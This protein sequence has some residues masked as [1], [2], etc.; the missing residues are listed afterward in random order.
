M[1]DNPTQSK[2][3]HKTIHINPDLFKIPENN[4][5]RKKR[6]PTSSGED[7]IKFKQQTSPIQKNKS[8]KNKLLKYIREK[9]EE[10]YKKMFDE[11]C[12]K[13]ASS[14]PKIP[15]PRYPLGGEEEENEFQSSIHFFNQLEKE[16]PTPAPM[17]AVP[18]PVP[19]GSPSSPLR[20]S[21]IG[22][23]H[24]ATVKQRPSHGVYFQPL[25][26]HCTPPVGATA[27]AASAAAPCISREPPKYG[28]LKNGKLPTY[29][30]FMNRTLNNYGSL[31]SSAAPCQITNVSPHILVQ[32]PTASLPVPVPPSLESALSPSTP[33]KTAKESLLDAITE[34]RKTKEFLS[35]HKHPISPYPLAKHKRKFFKQKKTLRRTYHVG[36]SKYHP[37]V[38]VLVSNRTIRNHVSTKSQL[39]KQVS[40]DEVKLYL[41]KNGFIKVGSN[42]PEDVLRKMYESAVLIGGE[43]QNHNPENLLYNYLHHAN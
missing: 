39:L 28:C 42:A 29:R 10:N 11:T 3:E 30:T 24:N 2:G 7:K 36:K 27:A 32:N 13:H 33:T 35:Q 18:P 15:A 14:E 8:I 20:I 31:S 19:F 1:N 21:N 26:H 25:L 40:M 12:A 23:S 43:I 41:V 6:K 22:T 4:R 34:S 17:A 16:I 37:K 38:S 9:Q 5:T